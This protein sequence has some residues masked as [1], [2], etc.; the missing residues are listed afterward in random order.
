MS[1]ARSEQPVVGCIGLGHMGSA[2]AGSIAA[3]GFEMVVYDVVDPEERAP[4]GARVAASAAEVGAGADVVVLSLPN[5]SI[6]GAVAEELASSG[7]R[8]RDVVD[9]STVG[10]AAARAASARLADAGIS[11]VD[12][13]VSGGVRAARTRGI[14]LMFSGPDDA[15]ER[16]GAVLASCGN[17]FRVGAEAGLGQAMK[18][19][20]NYLVAC[21]L[22]ATSEAIAFGRSF[23]LEMAD[24]LEVLNASSG[25]SRATEEKFPNEVVTQRYDAGFSNLLMLKDVGLYLEAVTAAGLPDTVGKPTV[26]VWRAF[27]AAQ[28]DVD[29]TR[30]YPFIAGRED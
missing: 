7:E 9:T 1:T 21:T 5:G 23:G 2:L 26:E 11:Y 14:S 10:P 8:L 16:V 22:A 17:V 24:M 19:A 3:A 30:I 29:F 28:P 18:L 25:R 13:P 27:V 6:V 20:N 15:F 4:E 12:A